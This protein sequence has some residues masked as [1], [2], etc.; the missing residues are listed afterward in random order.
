MTPS[1]KETNEGEWNEKALRTTPRLDEED[2]R[3]TKLEHALH[4]NDERGC[5]V[6]GSELSELQDQLTFKYHKVLTPEGEFDFAKHQVTTCQG[7]ITQKYEKI[8]KLK[9]EMR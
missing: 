4:E 8:A 3:I 6:D 2:K 5:N 1:K 9:A 7:T